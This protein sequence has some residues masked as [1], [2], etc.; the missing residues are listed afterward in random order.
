MRS[1]IKIASLVAGA[2]IPAMVTKAVP[3]TKPNVVIILADDMGYGDISCYNSRQVKTANIDRLAAEGIRLTDFYAPTPYSA[4]SRATLLTGRFPLRHGLVQNPAPDA[5]INETGIN[6]AEV[7]MGEIFQSEGY[8]TKCIGKWHLGHKPE[9][10][11]VKHGFDEYYGILYSND[12][13]PVQIIENMDTVEYP[14]NQNL[15]TGKYTEKA[16]DFI[17]RNRKNPFFLYL[18][19]AM[20]HKPLAA[21]EKFY[22]SGPISDLYAAAIKELDWSTG[23]IIKELKDQKLLENTIVIFMSDNG[24]WYGGST[25][26]LKGMK[27]TNWE[28]GTRVP[29]IIRFPQKLPGNRTVSVPCWSPDILPTIMSLAGIRTDPSI[30]LDGQDI[31]SIFLGL[32]KTHNPVFTMKDKQIKTIRD[33]KWKLFV[34]RPDFYK[35]P[36]MSKWKDARGPD[37]KTIIA[38]FNQA[39]PEDY[40]GIKPEIMEGDFLLFDLEKDPAESTDVSALH[41]EIKKELISKYERFLE[42]LR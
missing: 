37:G 36:D 41:P 16:L 18:A 22:T 14:V 4:P 30:I 8:H 40:P 32:Q 12:M 9:F 17:R 38:P 42:S 29:F 34:A 5:G 6:A 19:H 39:T 10:F 24:P 26:G 23:M 11:P 33:G 13:R 3:P 31:T 25:G 28:G 20:P 1:T 27:A 2:V 21:S 35:K 15:L 7:T